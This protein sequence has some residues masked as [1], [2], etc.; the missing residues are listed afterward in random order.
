MRTT[1]KFWKRERGREREKERRVLLLLV[2]SSNSSS[3]IVTS[4]TT[5]TTTSVEGYWHH[6]ADEKTDRLSGWHHD[7][8][9]HAVSGLGLGR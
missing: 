1:R 8:D 4:T 7:N 9:L 3:T 2:V 6:R 5:I